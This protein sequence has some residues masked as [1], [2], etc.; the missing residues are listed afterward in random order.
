MISFTRYGKCGN[1]IATLCCVRS[2]VKFRNFVYTVLLP[3]EVLVIIK[4]SLY[5]YFV[6]PF[7]SLS[8]LLSLCT[9]PNTDHFINQS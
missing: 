6:Q 4:K 5:E 3:L 9:L 8:K 1:S 2:R 7:E